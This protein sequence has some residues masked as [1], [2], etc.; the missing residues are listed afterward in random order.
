MRHLN[1]GKEGALS[2]KKGFSREDQIPQVQDLTLRL[3]R[4]QW[5]L[6]GAVS[7]IWSISQ[8]SHSPR[9]EAFGGQWDD[10][11]LCSAMIPSLVCAGRG[12]TSWKSWVLQ[13]GLEECISL[14]SSS[15]LSL[16]ASCLLW[17]EQFSFFQA[18]PPC[19][20]FRKASWPWT[21]MPAAGT[22]I[23]HFLI[24]IV[25]VSSLSDERSD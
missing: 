2:N 9:G 10:R 14:S 8:N 21:E 24:W 13:K 6:Q 20:G 1:E 7:W 12:E 18:F 19:R 5:E 23:K 22:P 3:D 4:R 17:H 16:S 15:F 11:M 25:G